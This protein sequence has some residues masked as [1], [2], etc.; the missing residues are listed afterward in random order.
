MKHQSITAFTETY[1]GRAKLA[2]EHATTADLPAVIA[3]ALQPT[4]KA[5]GEAL[6]ALPDDDFRAAGEK[7]MNDRTAATDPLAASRAFWGSGLGAP[8]EQER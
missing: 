5:V 7:V 6:A 3:E 8:T 4:L 2:T 1:T